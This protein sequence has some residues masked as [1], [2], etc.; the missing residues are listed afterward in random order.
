[1]KGL[2]FCP[3]NAAKDFPP[4]QIAANLVRLVQGATLA[5]TTSFS[6]LVQHLVGEG[7][8]TSRVADGLWGY[9]YGESVSRS[10]VRR[11]R[12]V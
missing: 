11:W 7:I 8:I 4:N 5:E 3:P 2:Y 9:V 6:E 12:E 1:M 10:N